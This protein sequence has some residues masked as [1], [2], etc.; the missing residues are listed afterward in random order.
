MTSSLMGATAQG[1]LH[2]GEIQARF[3]AIM[4]RGPVSPRFDK[5]K[6]R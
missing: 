2:P 4:L 3:A 5:A 6:R 1:L